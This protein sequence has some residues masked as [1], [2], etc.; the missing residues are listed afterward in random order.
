MKWSGMIIWCSLTCFV[1][2]LDS[3]TDFQTVMI[4]W[5]TSGAVFS[6][7]EIKEQF[8][9]NRFYYKFCID[10][11]KVRDINKL[12]VF[13]RLKCQLLLWEK[14]ATSIEVAMSKMLQNQWR[15]PKFNGANLNSRMSKWKR[16]SFVLPFDSIQ[17][18]FKHNESSL[19]FVNDVR[20]HSSFYWLKHLNSSND[21]CF[22]DSVSMKVHTFISSTHFVSE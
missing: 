10:K 22:D 3:S 14:W 2:F 6:A 8:S 15:R 11:L 5:D 1:W 21:Y 9:S 16:L 19:Y 20:N 18:S 17:I 13:W 4:A 7:S 12:C